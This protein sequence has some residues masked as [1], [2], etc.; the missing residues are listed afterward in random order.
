MSSM[1]EL[2]LFFVLYVK[3]K[4]EGIF[5]SQDKYVAEI[6]KKF[7]FLSVKTAS[8]P[9]ETQKPLVKDEEATDVDVTLKTSHLQAVKRI[10]RYLKGQ[11]KLGLWY[12]KVSSFD[13]EA[14]LDSDY[15]GENIDRKSTTGVFHSKTK[16]IEVR[17]HF[18]RDA[19]EKK[20][21]KVLKI[22]TDD[23]VAGLLTK[24]FDHYDISNHL[25]CYKL[26]V[27]ILKLG[28]MSYHKDIY[29]NPSLTKK[30]FTNMK[31]VGTGFSGV[32]TSLFDTMLVLATKEVVLELESEVIDIKSTYKDG[33]EKLEGRVD[34]LDEENGILK[35]LHNVHSKVDTDAPIAKPYKMD[36]EHQ[37]KV[38]SMQDVDDEEPAELEEVLEVVKAAKLMT[39]VVTTTGATTAEATKV[40]VPRRRRGGVIQDP[41]ETTSTVV[42]HLEVQSKD[43]GKGILIEEPKSLKGQAQ[44]KQDEA[45]A[46][47]LEAELNANI[48]WNAIMEQVKRSERL[49]DAVIKYQDLNRKPLIEAQA[50][51]NMIIYLNNMASFKMNYFKGMAYSE[52]RPLF[53]K[54][55]NYIQDFLEEV[56]KEVTIPEKEDEV[57]GHKREEISIDTFNSGALML[58]NVRLEVEEVSEMSFELLRLVRRQ[59]IEGYVPE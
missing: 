33:I 43:K 45:F 58:N 3:Q 41:E 52:I 40:N 23:N 31:R 11:P 50:R 37:E 32:V 57:E 44:I 19:Y 21:I 47:Q 20:L 29:D 28:D 30:V 38:L 49:N 39:E 15:A 34:K 36:L 24:A 54:H 59:L 26:K 55:Y 2:T 48:K 1:G 53:E 46:R 18:I 5:I 22:H 13:L 10:F 7:H 42:V 35:D 16:N 51:K 14:Y 9:I 6:L 12:L 27:Q 56:N 17:H 4:E 8:T 25:S